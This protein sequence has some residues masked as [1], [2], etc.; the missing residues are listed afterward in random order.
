MLKLPL[1]IF[2]SNSNFLRFV[3][4]VVSMQSQE[5]INVL[6]YALFVS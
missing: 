1:F 6:D 4:V 2:S 3:S 5:V